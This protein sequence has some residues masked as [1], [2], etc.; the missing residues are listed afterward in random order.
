M[1]NVIRIP[2]ILLALLCA[3]FL[4][5]LFLH[6]DDVAKAVPLVIGETFA[7]DSKTLGETRR[8]NVYILTSYGESHKEPLPVLYMPDGGLPEDFLLRLLVNHWV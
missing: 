3:Q 2:R 4:P 8:I 7:I 6:C 1:T 5:I